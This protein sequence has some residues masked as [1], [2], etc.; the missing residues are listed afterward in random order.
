[1]R[2]LYSS[3]WHIAQL[4]SWVKLLT[5]LFGTCLLSEILPSDYHCAGIWILGAQYGCEY[6]EELSKK[7][8]CH[9]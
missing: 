1:M 2:S 6:I 3:G 8:Y 4:S 7:Q 5:H 9:G